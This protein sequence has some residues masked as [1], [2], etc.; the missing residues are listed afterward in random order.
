V[1]GGDGTEERIEKWGRF[2][3]TQILIKIA[4]LRKAPCFLNIAK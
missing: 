4:V 1:R 2:A 3:N